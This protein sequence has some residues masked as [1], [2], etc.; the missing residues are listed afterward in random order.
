MKVSSLAQVV[1]QTLKSESL[2]A[3]HR[4]HAEM[5]LKILREEGVG[6]QPEV[7]IAPPSTPSPLPG[8]E[9][10]TA[11][12]V[13][14][15][16]LLAVGRS[17]QAIAQ[18]LVVEVGTVKRHVS[19]IMDKLQVASRLEAVARARALNLLPS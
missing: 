15:L 14:V 3:T 13:E 9:L 7:A 5:L 11:R 16:H 19:N 17:N 10:L 4:S 1:T 18:E 12:E 8:G 2:A 6:A